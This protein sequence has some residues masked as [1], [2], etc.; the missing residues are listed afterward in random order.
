MN[1][2]P[3]P[4][5]DELLFVPL[6][7]SGEIGMNLNLYGCDGRWVMIDCGVSFRDERMPGGVVVMPDIRALEGAEDRLEGLVVTHAHE[8]HHGAVG[9]LWRRL[10]CPVLATPFAA[11]LLRDKLSDAGLLD[12]VPV[13]PVAPGDSRRLGRFRVEYVPITHSIPESHAIALTTPAGV[14]LHTGD[15]KLDPQPGVGPTTDEVRLRQLGEAGVLAL[16]C[17]ST[18]ALVAGEAGSEGGIAAAL[19]PLV[20]GQEGLVAVAT[21]ASNVARLRTVAEVARSCGR[22]MA[23]VGRSLWRF[24]QA[25]R[26]AGYLD[27]VPDFVDEAAIRS[28][29]RRGLLVVCTGSQGEPRAALSRILARRHRALRF[30]PGDR[31]IFSSRVIPG[32][33]MAVRRIWNGL[34]ELGCDVVTPDQAPIHVSGHPARDELERMYSWIRPRIALP[35]H[36]EPLHIRAHARLARSLQVPEVCEPRNGRV[37]RLAPGAAADIGRVASGRLV[38]DGPQV[39][40]L[41]AGYLEDRRRMALH[42]A[43][44][45]TLVAAGPEDADPEIRVTWHG[46]DPSGTGAEADIEGVVR[47]IWRELVRDRER[48]DGAARPRLARAVRRV[49]RRAQLGRPAVAVELI[50]PA[51]GTG[52]AA[53][54]G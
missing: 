26:Q 12:E 17:D 43:V 29:P 10:R 28:H 50:R 2:L 1:G 9:H 47:E 44:T 3:V 54:S 41:D 31:V 22:R 51:K 4:G 13:D 19:A 6:G 46:L 48:A 7:G 14:V 37:I 38:L 8:D 25:A 40:P 45:V 20:E 23:L 24:T 30:E 35:V 15:W 5:P 33:E 18:N 53:D 16:T 34:I 42:G 39:V 27:G 49:C 21:F 11:A 52:H 32:N 36:G